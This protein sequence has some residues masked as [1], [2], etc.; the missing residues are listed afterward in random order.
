MNY[1]VIAVVEPIVVALLA[2]L[3][4]LARSDYPRFKNVWDYLNVGLAVLAVLGATWNLG[5]QAAITQVKIS[6]PLALWAG[7]ENAGAN[8]QIPWVWLATI[9]VSASY[10]SLLNS[11]FKE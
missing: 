4:V 7:I 8:A 1:A 5:A 9:V 11:I 10:L 6:E 2:A 3:T